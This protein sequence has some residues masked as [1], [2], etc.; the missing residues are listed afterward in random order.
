MA[1]P[2]KVDDELL[3]FA[4]KTLAEA[5]TAVEYKRALCTTLPFDLGIDVDQISVALKISR[6]TVLRLRDELEKLY[7]GEPDSR[8]DWGGRRKSLLTEKEE[9]DFCSKW[10]NKALQGQVTSIIPMHHELIGIVGHDIPL[11]TTFRMLSRHGWRKIKPDT[12][13]PKSDL[14]TQDEFKKKLKSLWLPPLKN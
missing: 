10:E 5:E 11:S 6:R 7:H 9:E 3:S 2:F 8:D 1:R 12:K 4:H 13:H 14:K